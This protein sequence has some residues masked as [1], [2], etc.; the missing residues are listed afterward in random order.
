MNF[1]A[2]P[3]GTSGF[4]NLAIALG[5]PSFVGST[6]NNVA[7]NDSY[8]QTSNNYAIFTHNIIS[9]TDR[10]KLTLGARYTHEKKIAERVDLPDNNRLCAVFVGHRRSS[11]S[12][13]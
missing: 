6:L 8:R 1:S 5:G 7:L 13:A 9:F 3:F 12:R 4:T 2:A 10:L 11:S